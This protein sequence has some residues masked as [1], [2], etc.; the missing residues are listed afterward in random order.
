MDEERKKRHTLKHPLQ[1]RTHTLTHSNPTHLGVRL[2][3]GAVIDVGT[4]THAHQREQA[5]PQAEPSS[6]SY[7]RNACYQGGE[8]VEG[9]DEH[10]PAACF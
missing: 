8:E 9:D 4:R 6:V 5:M 3:G 10:G 1:Q 7:T 2:F